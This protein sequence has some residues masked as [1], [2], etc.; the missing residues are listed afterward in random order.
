MIHGDGSWG[1]NMKSMQ[2]EKIAK[3]NGE[4]KNFEHERLEAHHVSPLPM[5]QVKQKDV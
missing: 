5:L 3:T 1:W 2:N 4:N